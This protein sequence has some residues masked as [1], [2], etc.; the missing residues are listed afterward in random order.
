MTKQNNE[1]KNV[2]YIDDDPMQCAF[3]QK[4]LL[5]AGISCQV[6]YNLASIESYMKHCFIKIGLVISDINGVYLKD[7]V[8][9]VEEQLMFLGQYKCKV[10]ITSATDPK[11][12]TH[13]EFCHKNKIIRRIKE[14]L[15]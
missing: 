6:F 13:F 3:I 11:E 2:V 4:I 1:N 7:D 12:K 10:I 8:E 15:K 9:S 5:R 14:L